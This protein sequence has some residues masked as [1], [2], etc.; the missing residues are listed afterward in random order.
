MAVP[1]Q[2]LRESS[3]ESPKTL[4]SMG[5]RSVA[6]CNLTKWPGPIILAYQLGRKDKT[7]WRQHVKP[8][9]DFLVNFVSSAGYPAP[10]TPQERWEE[11][12]GY[13]S[14]TIASEIA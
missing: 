10:Y 7:T 4:K 13:S 6:A 2:S 8:A 3:V 9:A 12:C 5:R 1:Q 11:Q 14:S